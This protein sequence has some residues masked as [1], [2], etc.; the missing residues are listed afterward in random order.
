MSTAPQ[1]RFGLAGRVC[2]VTG[3]GSGIGQAIATTL[4]GDGAIVAVLDRN[5]GGAQETLR[6]VTAAGG[7]GIALG[8]DVADPKSVEAACAAVRSKVGDAHVL[9]NNAGIIRP[10]ALADLS[11]ADWNTVL[12]VNLT[13]YFLCAQVFGRAMR[14]RRDGVLVHISSIAATQATAYSGSYSVSKAGVTMLSRLLAIEWGPD[15]VRSNAICPG[16]IQT[17]MVKEV[18]AVPGVVERRSE[19]VPSRRVGQPNDIA[20]AALFLASQR[21]S[22][23]NGTEIAVD[24]GLP[25]TLMGHIPRAGF[26]RPQG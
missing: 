6:L 9:V 1:D 8:C 14:A 16:M 13:G 4:A 24:G 2:V 21:S 7:S 15:G 5:E 12:S 17:P 3:G 20:Q 26:E 19:L 11:L 25:H 22:Y 18:Y 10:G 23:V